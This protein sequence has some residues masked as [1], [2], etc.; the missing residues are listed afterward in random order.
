MYASEDPAKAARW[1]HLEKLRDPSHVR[2]LPL[3]ELRRLF[4]TVGLGAP[5]EAFYEIRDSVKNLL[6]RS[7]P[8][9]GDAVKIAQMFRASA[10]DGRLGVECRFV[11]GELRYAYPTVILSAVRV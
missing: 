5:V 1:N 7:F 2:C 3:S 10:N 9:P 8:Q 6:S 4:V 11:D